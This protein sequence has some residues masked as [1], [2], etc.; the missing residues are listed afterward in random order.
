[1]TC[2]HRWEPTDFGIKYRTP[3]YYMYRCTRCGHII[4]TLPKEI[5]ACK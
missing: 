3:N 1:M 5:Q 2:K 4:T